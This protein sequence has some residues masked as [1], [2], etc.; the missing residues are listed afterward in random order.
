MG[1]VVDHDVSAP[2]PQD[3]SRFTALDLPGIALFAAG[4]VTLLLF[5]SALTTPVWWLLALALVLLTTFI[6]WERR[7]SDPLIDVRMLGMNA[8]LQRTY[9]RQ[10]LIGLGGLHRALRSQPVDGRKRAPFTICGRPDTPPAVRR[11]HC[12]GTSEL[13]RAGFGGR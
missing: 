11:K 10:T 3:R 12:A 9:L 2:V 6:L 8:P 7:V 4:I 13:Q 1:V 5:L